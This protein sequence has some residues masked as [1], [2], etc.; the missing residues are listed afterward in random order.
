MGDGGPWTV[1][2]L[3]A[4]ECGDK[5]GIAKYTEEL[6]NLKQ[7]VLSESRKSQDEILYGNAG[8]LYCLLLIRKLVP[9]A[10]I[11]DQLI[12]EVSFIRITLEQWFSNYGT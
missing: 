11:E 7:L 10:G 4:K 5:E 9:E 6:V 2:I 12:K 3:H 8:Y 1:S